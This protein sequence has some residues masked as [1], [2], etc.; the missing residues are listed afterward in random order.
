MQYRN[1]VAHMYERERFDVSDYSISY[2]SRENR[3]HHA[4]VCNEQLH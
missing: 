2:P 3:Q 1:N 4:R